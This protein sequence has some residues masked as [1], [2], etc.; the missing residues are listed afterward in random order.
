MTVM[1]RQVIFPANLK[2][3]KLRLQSDASCDMFFK[4]VQS[5][6]TTNL[7]PFSPDTPPKKG[8]HALEL[9]IDASTF[10]AATSH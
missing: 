1:M 10:K 5:H 9:T 6:L 7:V 2:V 3:L 4:R 8:L